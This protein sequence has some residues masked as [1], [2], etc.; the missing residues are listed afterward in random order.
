MSGSRASLIARLRTLVGGRQPEHSLR[1]SIAELVQEAAEA[2]PDPDHPPED[3]QNRREPQPPV[4]VNIE[5][6]AKTG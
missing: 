4:R 1:E 3:R 6:S 2:H 5:L